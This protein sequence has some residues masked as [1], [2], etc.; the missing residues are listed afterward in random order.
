[1]GRQLLLYTRGYYYGNLNSPP[2]LKR[3]CLRRGFGIR[4]LDNPHTQDSD[5]AMLAVPHSLP[6]EKKQTSEQVFKDLRMHVA[7]RGDPFKSHRLLISKHHEDTK[8]STRKCGR[9]MMRQ[10]KRPPSLVARTRVY[11]IDQAFTRATAQAP[12][13]NPSDHR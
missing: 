6:D 13:N 9:S 12:S 3:R 4:L 8:A 7:E 1:M 5:V 10:F 11:K 2:M